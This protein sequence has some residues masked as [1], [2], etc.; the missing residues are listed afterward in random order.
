MYYA[1]YYVQYVSSFHFYSYCV[2][3]TTQVA[4]WIS[5][6]NEAVPTCGGLGFV[7]YYVLL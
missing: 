7:C 3:R 1:L 5:M 4:M 6:I 2:V